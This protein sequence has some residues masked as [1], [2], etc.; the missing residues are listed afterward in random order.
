MKKK[1][2]TALAGALFLMLICSSFTLAGSIPITPFE[3]RTP[4]GTDINVLGTELAELDWLPGS[5][6][7]VN[8]NALGPDGA[9]SVTEFLY[10][11]KLV[12]IIDIDHHNLSTPTLNGQ[13]AVDPNPYE[14]TVV[15]RVW[16]TPTN[17]LGTEA[18][19]F[20]LAS[21][22]T[23][24]SKPNILEIYADVYDGVGT[25]LVSTPGL[26]ADV[27]AGAGFQ[28]GVLVLRAIPI[29]LNSVFR[30]T[31]T[32]G[33]GVFDN[34][35]YGTGAAQIIY[36]V[37]FFDPDFFTFPSTSDPLQIQVQFDGTLT[38]PPAGVVTETMWDG[39]VPDYYTG[40]SDGTTPFNTEDLLIKVDSNSHSFVSVPPPPIEC[41][42]TGGGV[43]EDGEILLPE[44]DKKGIL[45]EGTAAEADDEMA[46]AL[47]SIVDR[48]QFGGQVGAPTA[49]Q[50]QPYGEWTHHQQK[51]PMG[52]FT[53][54]AGTASAPEGTE[55]DI[56]TC[57]DPGYCDPARPA[58]AKQIDFEGVGTFKNMQSGPLQDVVVPDKNK[59]KRTLHYFRVHVEDIGEPGPGGKQPESPDCNHVI[60]TPID[61]LAGDCENCADVYQIEIYEDDSRE[62]GEV[63]IYSVGGF[64]DNGNLQIHPPI[65]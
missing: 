63:P 16:E 7:A 6:L 53:F 38:L 8:A 46:E 51:G 62:P 40:L 29:E 21:D 15:C 22:P 1:I 57:S 55:I 43:S 18:V 10:Q 2:M 11:L 3:M 17:A 31:D 48:Y 30:V 34:Q 60:G 59:V 41:R 12:N 50:P 19:I 35:D 45:V 26:Q 28:D 25:A 37:E 5:G 65:K 23:G 13:V 39:T 49:S 64:I 47:D 20:T 54:H 58:P 56:V 9:G 4:Y 33:N 52:M 27:P 24:G 14:F 44:L 61:P 32:N 36:Q 42:M